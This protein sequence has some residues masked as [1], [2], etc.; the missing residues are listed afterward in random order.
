MSDATTPERYVDRK[1]LAALMGV[2]VPTITRWVRAGMP[3]ETWG[4]RVRRFQPSVCIAWARE[5]RVGAELSCK[6][7]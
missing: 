4:L 7:P 3:S 1:E 2:S 5:R 6:A